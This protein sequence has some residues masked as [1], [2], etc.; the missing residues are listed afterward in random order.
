MSRKAVYS[1]TLVLLSL[2]MIGVISVVG[3]LQSTATIGTSGIV[4]QPP[5]PSP[6]PPEAICE[7]YVYSDISCTQL[8]TSIDWGSVEA[9]N[10]VQR[11][12][13]I[14]N[15]GNQNVTLDLTTENWTPLEAADYLQLSWDYVVGSIMAPGDVVEVTFTLTIDSAVNGIESFSFDIV[16]IATAL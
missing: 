11:T 3:L 1:A 5:P 8:I 7:I 15:S 10:S 2:A 14:K 6:P 13:Y 16:I 4:V 12:V 9:G